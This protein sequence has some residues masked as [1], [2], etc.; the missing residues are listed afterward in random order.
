MLRAFYQYCYKH[1]QKEVI[2]KAEKIS[3]GVETSTW[4]RTLFV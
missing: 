1:W 3:A 2:P 4:S